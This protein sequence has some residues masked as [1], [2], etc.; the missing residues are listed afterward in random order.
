MTAAAEVSGRPSLFSCPHRC[1]FL[2]GPEATVGDE[3]ATPSPMPAP[4]H[5]GP[6]QSEETPE[7]PHAIFRAYLYFKKLLFIWN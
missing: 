4:M 1:N 6:S 5:Q 3:A 7:E 2:D